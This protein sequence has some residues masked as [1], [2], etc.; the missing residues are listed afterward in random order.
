VRWRASPPCAAIENA[1]QRQTTVDPGRVDGVSPY[2]YRTCFLPSD[3]HV[4]SV[5]NRAVRMLP[6][7]PAR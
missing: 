5:Q 3:C 2:N 7:R 1:L 4:D 6:Y